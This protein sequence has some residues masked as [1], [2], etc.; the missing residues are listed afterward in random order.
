[1]NR[2]LRASF[3]DDGNFIGPEAG[4]RK[5]FVSFHPPYAVCCVLVV[6]ISRLNIIKRIRIITRITLMQ[7]CPNFSGILPVFTKRLGNKKK[8]EREREEKSNVFNSIS[9]LHLK[10]FRYRRKQYLHPRLIKRKNVNH[11][12]FGSDFNLTN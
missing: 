12:P 3:F 4:Y 9:K 6:E 8:R 1:M 2:S 11:R 10:I 7:L 5:C